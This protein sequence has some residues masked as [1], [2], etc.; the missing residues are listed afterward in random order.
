MATP[1]PHKDLRTQALSADERG[2][3]LMAVPSITTITFFKGPVRVSGLRDI[4]S[5]VLAANP[6]LAGRLV[7]S[8][9]WGP[10][11]LLY[12]DGTRSDNL[13]DK[14]FAEIPAGSHDIHADMPYELLAGQVLSLPV[15][16]AGRL[17]INNDEPLFRV[18]LTSDSKAPGIGFALLVSMSHV[19]A[20]GNTYYQVLNMLSGKTVVALNP[21]RIDISR[22]VGA[23]TGG[24]TSSF[25]ALVGSIVNSLWRM[26]FV[27]GYNKI[28]FRLV[29]GNKILAAKEQAC[30]YGEVPFVS[31]NDIITSSLGQMFK[32]DFVF[33][34]INW[35]GRI[36]GCSMDLAGN[37]DSSLLINQQDCATPGLFRKAFARACHAGSN[38]SSHIRVF[39]RFMLSKSMIITNWASFPEELSVEGCVKTLHLPVCVPSMINACVIF[40]PRPGELAVLCIGDRSILHDMMEDGGCL[41]AFTM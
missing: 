1:L 25:A 26:L 29:S 18:C 38:N 7:R 34:A 16:K 2:L 8:S 33:M 11:T 17:C 13:T 22:L 32:T 21:M 9:R 10:V 24:D 28:H 15:V 23:A 40:K 37:Y 41:T 19:I 20:D 30:L 3:F 12:Q 5:S 36:D 39:L 6:W 27:T 31:T 4:V 14:V 35:R